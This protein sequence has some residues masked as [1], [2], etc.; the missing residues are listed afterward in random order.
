MGNEKTEVLEFLKSQYIMSVAVCENSKPLS[1]ILLYYID[2]DF[3]I[4][5][6]THTDSYKSKALKSNPKIS[7]SI[8]EANQMLVQIDGDV[9]EI[10]DTELKL[11]TI[12][13]LAESAGKKDDFWP[14]LLRIKGENYVVF[15]IIPN[16]IRKLDLVQN[17]MTQIDSPFTEIDIN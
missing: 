17:T 7:L 14:P 1:S 15:K 16:W 2:D 12:D 9:E 5:F 6:A 10:I 3:N 8:W 4:H 11:A 13:N